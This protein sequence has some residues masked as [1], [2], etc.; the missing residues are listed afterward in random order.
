MF[1]VH[2]AFVKICKMNIHFGLRFLKHHSFVKELQGMCFEGIWILKVWTGPEFDV[3]KH[4][5]VSVDSSINHM[6]TWIWRKIWE[7]SQKFMGLNGWEVS[8]DGN[9]GQTEFEHKQL[10]QPS[11]HHE[12]EVKSKYSW[13]TWFMNSELI[14]TKTISAPFVS[15]SHC[16]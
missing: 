6:I 10:R 5:N 1:P 11:W 4:I 7:V 14:M 16:L 2:Q 13:R 3:Q 8:V 9:R 12:H 15:V